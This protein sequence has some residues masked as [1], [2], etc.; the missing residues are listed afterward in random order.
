MKFITFSG[1]FPLNAIKARW[2]CLRSQ[3]RKEWNKI[4][5]YV[6]SGSA[7]TKGKEPS[8]RHYYQMSFLKDTYTFSPYVFI[9]NSCYLYIL[10]RALLFL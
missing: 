10:I 2:R 7:S 3:H 9:T 5:D 1:K 4:N 8:F 6:P